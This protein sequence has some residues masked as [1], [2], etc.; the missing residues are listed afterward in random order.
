MK[1]SSR[2]S[3][4]I[5]ILALLELTPKEVPTSGYIAESVKTNPVVI[6]RILGMLKAAEL[7]EVK[8]GS[9]GA[10]LI[11]SAQEITL[12]DIYKAVGTDQEGDL[13]SRP[14]EANYE[15]PVGAHIRSV[16]DPALEGAQE[17]MEAELKKVTLLD[18]VQQLRETIGGK[19]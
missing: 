6:R 17:A 11:K 18:I 13:F 10:F 5:H 15:C 16:V 4:A 3:V 14:A 9:G 8:R 1:I 2:F 19:L 12:L 7:V